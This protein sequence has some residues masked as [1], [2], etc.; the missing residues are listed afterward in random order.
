MV[1]VLGPKL[2]CALVGYALLLVW[3]VSCFSNAVC[4]LPGCLYT[5]CCL[6]RRCNLSC[7]WFFVSCLCLVPL[8][9]QQTNSATS[10]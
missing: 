5:T 3:N 8:V 2:N 6:F 1:A 9:P 10:L 4:T 7:H